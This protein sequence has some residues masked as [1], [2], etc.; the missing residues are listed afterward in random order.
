MNGP[1]PRLDEVRLSLLRIAKEEINSRESHGGGGLGRN[2][3]PVPPRGQNKAA[4]SLLPLRGFFLCSEKVPHSPAS[5]C[6][7]ITILVY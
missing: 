7:I 3:G 2:Q 1:S 6:G 5:L 4:I